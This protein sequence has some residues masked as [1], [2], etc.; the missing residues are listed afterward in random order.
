MAQQRLFNPSTMKRLIVLFGLSLM[1]TACG[2]ASEDGEDTSLLDA[3]LSG[4]DKSEEVADDEVKDEDRVVP[5]LVDPTK[6]PS[7]DE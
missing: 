1:L 5:I 6:P 3:I 7:Y 2:S 4:P